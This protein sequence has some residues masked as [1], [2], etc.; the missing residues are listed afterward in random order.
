MGDA[1]DVDGDRLGGQRRQLLHDHARGCSTAPEIASRQP[2]AASTGVG[3]F[4]PP[5]AATLES[6][7]RCAA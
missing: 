1:V 3:P 5:L 2:S 4:P 6:A 7:V